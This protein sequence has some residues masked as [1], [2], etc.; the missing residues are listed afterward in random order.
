MVF[1]QGS[2][3]PQQEDASRF[4]VPPHW[5]APAEP[6]MPLV[7]QWIDKIDTLPVNWLWRG[8]L[9]MGRLVL[10]AGDPGIGKSF[11]ALDIAARISTGASWP[12]SPG[13]PRDPVNVL[14]FSI[15]DDARDTIAPRLKQAG[16]ALDRVCLV[17]GIFRRPP[18][19]GTDFK[20]RFRVP[21]DLPSLRKAI[22]DLYPVKL[23]VFDPIMAYCGKGD[24]SGVSSIHAMLAPL[25]E[26]AMEMA[27]TVLC[28]IHLKNGAGRRAIYRMAGNP[29]FTTASRSVWGLVRDPHDAKRRLMVPVKMNLCPATEGLA[30]RIED[31]GTVVWEQTP[32]KV[33][34]DRLLA[35]S[36][37]SRKLDE[38]AKWLRELLAGGSRRM[39][40]VLRLAALRDISLPTLKRAKPLIGVRSRRV[41]DKGRQSW[42][43]ELGEGSACG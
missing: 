16:A 32:V 22:L 27:V 18:I 13:C 6:A 7:S 33:D 8:R 39:T 1:R 12:D 4:E 29:A 17:E 36:A 40:E 14:V 26:M 42:L 43:W 5:T 37:A 24:G 35:E 20:R 28:T 30:F 41:E 10:L 31:E 15:E 9:P 11:V 2:P 34:A 21:E 38:A 19:R 23:V 25:A 3:E